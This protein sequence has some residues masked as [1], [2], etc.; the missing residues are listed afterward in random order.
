MHP[1]PRHR[2]LVLLAVASARSR[3]PEVLNHAPVALREAIVDTVRK[4]RDGV[5]DHRTGH[6]DVPSPKLVHPVDLCEINLR[7]AAYPGA[8]L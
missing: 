1:W 3:R 2:C 7:V 6:V 5:E 4:V 8:A